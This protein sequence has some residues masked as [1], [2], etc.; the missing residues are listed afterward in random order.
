L[1]DDQGAKD[2][3]EPSRRPLK[4]RGLLQLTVSG[5]IETDP[6]IFHIERSDWIR[7][8]HPPLVK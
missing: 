6:H 3:T 1:R 7:H 2:R 4:V 5:R 8:R